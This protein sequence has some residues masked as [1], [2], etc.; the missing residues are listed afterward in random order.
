[1]PSQT[2]LKAVQLQ[3][4]MGVPAGFQPG[5]LRPQVVQKQRLDDF[6]DVLLGSVVCALGAALGV[7]C[8]T[9]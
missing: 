9:D 2:L 4:S 3:P 5:E 6:Q 1:M 8:M 7:G